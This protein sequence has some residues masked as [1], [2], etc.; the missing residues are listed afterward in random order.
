MAGQIR[1]EDVWLILSSG[2]EMRLGAGGGIAQLLF[3]TTECLSPSF[4][5]EVD[6]RIVQWTWWSETVKNEISSLPT[7]E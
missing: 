6:D 7:F 3:G 2:F 4:A 1:G 5:G